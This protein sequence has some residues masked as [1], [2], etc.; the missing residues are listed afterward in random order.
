M[1][2]QDLRGLY[3]D[4][5]WSSTDQKLSPWLENGTEDVLHVMSILEPVTV[6]ELSLAAACARIARHVYI[7]QEL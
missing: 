6:P 3:T 4:T 2:S 1:M 7:P 5:V